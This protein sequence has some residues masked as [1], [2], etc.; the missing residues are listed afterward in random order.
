MNNYNIF[1]DNC[2]FKQI[3]KSAEDLKKFKIIKSSSV[4]KNLPFMDHITNKTYLSS[5]IELPKKLKCPKCGFAIRPKLI[6]K[7]EDKN[8]NSY[9]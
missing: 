2:A 7:E 8:D 3:I 1:C 5:S 6:K 4:Q 9:K